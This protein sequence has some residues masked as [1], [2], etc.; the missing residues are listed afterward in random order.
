MSTHQYYNT[1]EYNKLS[2]LTK[3]T[4]QEYIKREANEWLLFE[5]KYHAAKNKRDLFV[6]YLHTVKKI[7][8][9]EIGQY[10]GLSLQWA[11][12]ICK[13]VEKQLGGENT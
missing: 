11:Q 4:L 5:L 12:N 2:K 10:Y 1:S 7:T 9:K 13:E 3:E 6:Y 8:Y